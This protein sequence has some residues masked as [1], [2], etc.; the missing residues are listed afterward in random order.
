M[1]PGAQQHGPR[2]L[3][4]RGLRAVRRAGDWLGQRELPVL[5]ALLLILVACWA[6]AEVADEALEGDARGFDEWAL[7]VLRQ[8]DDPGR[9]IGPLW[10]TEMARDLTALGGMLVLSLFALVISGFLLLRRM[11]GAACLLLSAI[12]G[13]VLLNMLLKYLFD[14]PRPDL[15]P[16]LMHVG[17]SS[18]P[19]GH[20][21][22]ATTMFLTLGALLSR[23]VEQLRL[24]AYIMFVALM[25]SLLVGISRVFLGVHYPT[26]V[27]AGW[28]AGLAWAVA[29]WLVAQT[30]QRRGLVERAADEPPVE[31]TDA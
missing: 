7:R 3:L 15:V 8:A 23:F 18:F 19:S 30:L 11:T 4:D 28:V 20:S 14:R 24:R 6:F 27:L 9:A 5:V 26:D 25:L 12:L 16:H 31:E 13:G 1:T 2:K 21:M 22:L 10:L 29:C 17:S